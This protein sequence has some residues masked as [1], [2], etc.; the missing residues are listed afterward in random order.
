MSSSAPHI[1][2]DCDLPAGMTLAGWRRA[3][4]YGR[5]RPTRVRRMLGLGAVT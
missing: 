5:V 3:Q 4:H 1:Y 2:V